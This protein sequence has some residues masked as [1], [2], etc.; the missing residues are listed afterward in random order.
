MCINLYT[1]NWIAQFQTVLRLCE[2]RKVLFNNRTADEGQK[3]DQVQQFLAH[4]KNIEISNGGKPFT[5]DMHRKIKVK[6]LFIHLYIGSM[7]YLFC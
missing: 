2:G 3:V 7:E 5:D 4:V 6:M 1:M